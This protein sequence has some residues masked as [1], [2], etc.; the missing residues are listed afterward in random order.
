ML[1]INFKIIL[2]YAVSCLF[3]SGCES[4]KSAVG[5]KQSKV[6]LE[7]I[8]FKAAANANNSTKME[9]EQS[10]ENDLSLNQVQQKIT[11]T[12]KITDDTDNNNKKK[13]TKK[14]GNKNRKTNKNKNKKQYKNK[15]LTYKRRKC[16]QRKT[17]KRQKK[18][19][20]KKRSL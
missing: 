5:I 19:Q 20:T 7:K 10:Y 12:H 18:R 8:N 6:W 17:M 2:F 9:A 1:S 4:V 15:R 16:K 14:G 11:E 3:F 13:I